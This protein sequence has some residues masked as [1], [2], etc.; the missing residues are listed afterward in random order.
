MRGGASRVARIA[1]FAIRIPRRTRRCSR[2]AR[3][4]VLITGS[5]S[6]D[7]RVLSIE[8]DGP[9]IDAAQMMP[10]LERGAR[11]DESGGGHGLG[12]AIA[13]DLAEATG[14]EISLARSGLGGLRVTTSWRR[15]TAG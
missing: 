3:R 11:L 1:P 10:A 12:L 2:F 13:R 5:V 4:R 9:G 14:A 7:G 8:D 15:L 6:A